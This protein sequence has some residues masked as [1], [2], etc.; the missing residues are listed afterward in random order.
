MARAADPLGEVLGVGQRRRQRDDPRVGVGLRRDVPH[1]RDDNLEHGAH[2][3][4]DEVGLVNEQQRDVLHVLALL[5]AARDHVPPLRRR[6]DQLTALEALEVGRRIAREGLDVEAELAKFGRPVV[7]AL[8]GERLQRRHVDG[9]AVGR[10]REHAQDG[11]L[12]AD[13][14]AGAGG[15]A[16]EDVLVRVVDGVEDLGL[17]RVEVREAEDGLPLGPLQRREGQRP[18][19][20]QLGVRGRGVGEDELGQRQGHGGLAAE[21]P[22]G[23]RPHKVLRRQRLEERDGEGDGLRLVPLELVQRPQLL[24]VDVLVLGVL[25]PDPP[26]LCAAVVAVGPVEGR[27]D[28]QHHAQH[29]PRDRLRAHL[30]L[31]QGQLRRF[32][33]DRVR[34]PLVGDELAHLLGANLAQRVDARALGLQLRVDVVRQRAKLPHRVVKV[35]AAPLELLGHAVD[36][37]GVREPS[38]AERDLEEAARDARGALCDERAIGDERKGA[39]GQAGDIGLHEDVG[40]ALAVGEARLDGQLALRLET[41]HL[42]HLL[43]AHLDVGK[44]GR[45]AE[46]VQDVAVAGRRPELLLK[47]LDRADRQVEVRRRAPELGR[48]ERARR[49][50]EAHHLGRVETRGHHLDQLR[51]PRVEPRVGLLL[52]VRDAID[53]RVAAHAHVEVGVREPRDSLFDRRDRPERDLGVEVVAKHRHKLRLDRQLLREHRQVVRQLR[54]RREDDALARRVKLRPP[55][56]PKDLH[57]VEH[58][59]VDERALLGV[60]QLRALDDHRVRREVDAPRQR[61]GA[62]EQVE[63]PVGKEPLRQRA[64]GAQH[65]RVV[66]AVAAGEELLHLG[67]ARLLHL[68]GEEVQPRVVVAVCEPLER[69]VLAARLL[70]HRARRAHRVVAR[71]HEDHHLLAVAQRGERLV[72]GDVEHRRLLFDWVGLCHAD[73]RLRERH[74]PIRVAKVMQPRLRVDAQEEG[75]VEVVGQGRR[76]ADDADHLLR[77]LDEAQR[78]RD[79]RLDDRPAVVVEQVHLVDDQQPDR[80]HEPV[81]ALARDDVPLLGR[82]DDQLR[83]EDLLL[84]QLHV[85]SVLAHL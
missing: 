46:R 40:L 49:R 76:E 73:E 17:H 48:V 58:A 19:V 35:P 50:V 16:D 74:R 78:A 81:G 12:G 13:G 1:P 24:V 23:D 21:P 9:A 72:V 52:V 53:H 56:A 22:I 62:H 68:L 31:E 64:V 54:M 11:E 29:R 59:Q 32:L 41:L 18:Q 80:L 82:R 69:L 60:V 79:E 36:L 44:L 28:R 20:E 5:P 43:L 14:L 2:L 63:Q 33:L 70:E 39:H 84:A 8:V 25:D 77:R 30:H 6:H 27:R 66:H 38:A 4:A 45:A 61:S 3:A 67:R 83:L 55:R 42:L 7:V 71:V 57:H 34:H 26:V 65:A 37:L 85:A 75:D 47:R 10:V 15:R 51:P